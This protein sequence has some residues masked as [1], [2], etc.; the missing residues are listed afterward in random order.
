MIDFDLTHTQA[1]IDDDDDVE[2]STNH[3]SIV[4][5]KLTMFAMPQNWPSIKIA[6]LRYAYRQTDAQAHHTMPLN[7]YIV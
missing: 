5:L 6:I 4:I 7:V 3:A 1:Q 2:I